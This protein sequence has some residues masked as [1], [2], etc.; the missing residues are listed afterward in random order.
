MTAP[1]V[2][3]DMGLTP[4]THLEPVFVIDGV[5]C[6]LHVGEMAAIPRGVLSGP[7]VATLAGEDYRIGRAIDFLFTGA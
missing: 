2:P 4:L 6:A 5:A 3:V 1:L 7:P